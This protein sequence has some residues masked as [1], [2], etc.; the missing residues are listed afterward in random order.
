MLFVHN[1]RKKK[2]INIRI[3]IALDRPILMQLL[4]VRPA[5]RVRCNLER[6][7]RGRS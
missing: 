2:K 6:R 1:R 7:M 4:T 5:G 3:T